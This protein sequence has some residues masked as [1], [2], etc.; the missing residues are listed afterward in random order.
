MNATNDDIRRLLRSFG[1]QAD[2]VI[3]AHA[4]N[5]AGVEVLR[6]RVVL[7]DTTD[8]G[9]TAP[10]QPRRLLELDGEVRV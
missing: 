1:I 7:E 5:A 2:E 10:S 8:Y 3:Q 4:K 6:L 9:G